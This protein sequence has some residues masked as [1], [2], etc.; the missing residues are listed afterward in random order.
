MT[1]LVTGIEAIQSGGLIRRVYEDGG[2]SIWYSADEEISYHTT[3]LK[4]ACFEIKQEDTNE[5]SI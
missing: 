4:T 3:E 1:K 5:K 2:F